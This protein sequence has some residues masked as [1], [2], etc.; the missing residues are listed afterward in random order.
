VVYPVYIEYI[1]GKK[2]LNALYI[3]A[4]NR[5]N[6][7]WGPHKGVNGEEVGHAKKEPMAGNILHKKV[8]YASLCTNIQKKSVQ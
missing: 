4:G 8:Q 2:Q 3:M 1:S 7:H 5:G 6:T